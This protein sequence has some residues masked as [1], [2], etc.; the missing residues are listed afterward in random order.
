MQEGSC[1][2]PLTVSPAQQ[3][4]GW[5]GGISEDSRSDSKSTEKR[6]ILG[7]G[8]A[9]L[10][11]GCSQH[12]CPRHTSMAGLGVQTLQVTAVVTSTS[13]ATSF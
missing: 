5:S 9:R 10:E 3:A 11:G 8:I 12:P 2:G 1:R 13:K 4:K 6:I 7:T